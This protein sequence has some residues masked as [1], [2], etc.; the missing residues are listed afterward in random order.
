MLRVTLAER[1]VSR[2]FVHA[3]VVGWKGKAIIIPAF[4]YRG[5]T[6]LVAELVKNGAVYFSDEYAVLDENGRVHPFPGDLSIKKSN[7]Y[8]RE[9]EISV[10][11]LGGQIATEPCE[12]GGVLITEYKADAEWRPEILSIGQGIIEMVA[13][14]IPIRFNTEFSLKVLKAALSRA[15]IAK[16]ARGEAKEFAPMLL[17]FFESSMN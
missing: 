17:S 13:H 4:S 5:K 10:S 6:T 2:V 15:I 12:I 16:G 14:T 7:S 3:G 9:T 8:E 1:A 11:N